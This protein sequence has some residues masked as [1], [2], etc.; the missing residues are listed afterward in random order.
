MNGAIVKWGEQVG[1]PVYS[2]PT[3]PVSVA[4]GARAEAGRAATEARE[5]LGY[6]LERLERRLLRRATP[7]PEA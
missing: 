2:E 1:V 7:A 4:R 5:A 3:D 6:R